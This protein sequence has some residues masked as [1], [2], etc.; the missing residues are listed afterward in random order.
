MA[1]KVMNV[2]K[3]LIFCV[4]EFQNERAHNMLVFMFDPCYKNLQ[5]IIQ[6]L[7]RDVAQILVAKYDKKNP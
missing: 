6:F 2:L 1:I 3:L 5:C 7:G 4:C